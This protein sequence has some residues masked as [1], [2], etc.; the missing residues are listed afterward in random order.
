MQGPLI[1]NIKRMY[2]Y[3]IGIDPGVET[4][5]AVKDLKTGHFVEIVTEPIHR[6]FRRVWQWQGQGKIAV[7]VEDAR[8]RKWF[9]DKGLSAKAS[10][11]LAMGGASVK[12][13]C[14]A[15]EDM[16]VDANIPHLLI[17]PKN[18]KT[19]VAAT[20]FKQLTGWE[21]RTSNHS[22]DAAMLIFT[23]N[24]KN[25]SIRLPRLV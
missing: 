24:Q 11:G 10:R 2:D 16:L 6:A 12:R 20:Y 1:S 17:A 23:A 18:N 7:F 8:K 4:G 15:W 21:R 14:K 25:L 22:R 19:K 13:D 3:L 5:I 9:N